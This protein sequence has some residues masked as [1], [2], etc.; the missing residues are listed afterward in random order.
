MTDK[1]YV[2]P[3]AL[4]KK[5]VAREFELSIIDIESNRRARGYVQARW[6]AMYL[7]REL[8]T[9]SFPAIGRHF[10]GRDH[11]SVVHGVQKIE[12]DVKAGRKL[13]A[14]ALRLLDQLRKVIEAGG[15]YDE[16]AHEACTKE[17]GALERELTASVHRDFE[18]L[19]RE[20]AHR[21][22]ALLEEVKGLADKIR[23]RDRETVLPLFQEVGR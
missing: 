7:V 2:S 23:A 18:L 16:E 17:L 4:I 13:G 15:Q 21:P 11:S 1:P 9:L 22:V 6:V 5:F 12:A 10:G 8:T 14:V 19:R 3:I 20:A